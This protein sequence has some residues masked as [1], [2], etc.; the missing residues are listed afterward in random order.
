M[1]KFYLIGMQKRLLSLIYRIA[2]IGIVF[3]RLPPHSLFSPPLIYCPWF[4]KVSSFSL[5]LQIHYDRIGEDGLFSH[6]EITVLFVP[7]LS[8]CLPALDA[9][10][11]QWL[12]YQKAVAERERQ[13]SLRKEVFFLPFLSF[14]PFLFHQLI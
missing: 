8:E 13:L 5:H 3:W 4:E 9:W 10:R 7:D 6:K 12:A 14:S 11:E 2:A 1:S